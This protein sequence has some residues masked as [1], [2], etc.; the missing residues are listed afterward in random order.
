ME[1]ALLVLKATALF[2][3]A[4]GVAYVYR[5]TPGRVHQLWTIAFAAILALPVLRVVVPPLNVPAL[6]RKICPAVAP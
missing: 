4:A 5:Q 3:G 6:R 2:L 1:P